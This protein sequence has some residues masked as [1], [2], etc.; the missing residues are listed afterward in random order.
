MYQA[1]DQ[2]LNKALDI[3]RAMA[4]KRHAA[5]P[6]SYVW[7]LDGLISAAHQAVAETLH[8]YDPARGTSFSTLAAHSVGFALNHEVRKQQ[9][10]LYRFNSRCAA[11]RKAGKPVGEKRTNEKQ[12]VEMDKLLPYHEGG[13][14]QR[15]TVGDLILIDPTDPQQI[16]EDRDHRRSLRSSVRSAIDILPGLDRKMIESRFYR[17]ETLRQMGDKYGFSPQGI[18]TRL[19]AIYRRLRPHLMEW[20]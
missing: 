11:Q 16:V 15:K 8:T 7:D 14:F 10:G 17:N 3:A 20:A 1:T 6:K 5:L 19:N 18:S 9:P 2:E 13:V 4:H 12:A